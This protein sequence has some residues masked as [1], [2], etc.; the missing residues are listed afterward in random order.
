MRALFVNPGGI[1]DQILLLPTVKIFKDNFPDYQAD[2]ICEPRSAVISE[3]TS[4]YRKVKTFYFKAINPN[5][6]K[7][8]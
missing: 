3:L 2:L 1:G 5:I 6:L 7:F 4:L 8:T